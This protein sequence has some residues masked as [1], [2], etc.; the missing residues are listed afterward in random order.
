MHIEGER[1]FDAPPDAVYRALTD[2]DELGKAF[3]VIERIDADGADW[4]VFV[5]LPVPGSP[6]L[7]LPVRLEELRD[8][9]HARLRAQGKTLGGRISVDSSFD[10]APAG[11]GTL[12]RWSADIDASGIFKGL[13]SQAL[14][15]VAEQ[16]ADRALGRLV[17][18]QV[19]SM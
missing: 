13:G 7:K 1:R 8:G 17:R 9:E 6:R 19:T 5:R 4:T 14:A 2:P 15:P 10:L 11:A 3:S 12:M 18:G 16:H